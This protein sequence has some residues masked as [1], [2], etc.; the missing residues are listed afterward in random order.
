[1]C[2]RKRPWAPPLRLVLL[3]TA[4]SALRAWESAKM[5]NTSTTEPIVEEAPEEIIAINPDA[6]KKQEE[7]K[8]AQAMID[9]TKIELQ[10]DESRQPS[11]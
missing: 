4:I 9:P 10:Y 7:T 6:P 5:K 3:G 2:S 8:D 11:Y 1:M